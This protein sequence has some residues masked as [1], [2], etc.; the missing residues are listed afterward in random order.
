MESLFDKGGIFMWPLLM[1]LFITLVIIVERWLYW[2]KIRI[3]NNYG[4]RQTI[5]ESNQNDS[6]VE[7]LK[8]ATD[9]PALFLAY[10]ALADKTLSRTDIENLLKEKQLSHNRFMRLLDVI[11]SVAPLFGILGTIWGIILSFNLAGIVTDIDPSE[12]MIGMSE[13]FITTAFGLIVSLASLFAFN[14]F[15]SLSERELT[16]NDIFLTKLLA[17]IE[18]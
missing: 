8:D 9:D 17:K 6:L 7:S 12:A 14:Y 5:L 18:S 10:R 16:M 3:E 1:S 2:L 15:Q 11:T 4:I 13:A